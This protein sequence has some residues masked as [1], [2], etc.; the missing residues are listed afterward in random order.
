VGRKV[1]SLFPT[2]YSPLPS[3]QAGAFNRAA[4]WIECA[5]TPSHTRLKR[6][7][8][9]RD[10][11]YDRGPPAEFHELFARLFHSPPCPISVRG[12]SEKAAFFDLVI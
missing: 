8:F 12:A 4:L 7:R 3:S 11:F 5:V 10:N 2:P 1:N 6:A 9:L